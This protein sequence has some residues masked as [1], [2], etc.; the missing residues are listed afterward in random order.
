MV[1]VLADVSRGGYF[2]IAGNGI[3]RMISS[4]PT[5][6]ERRLKTIDW[7][8]QGFIACRWVR[9]KFFGG[10]LGGV[11]DGSR[12][13]RFFGSRTWGSWAF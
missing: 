2:G 13:S 12:T 9:E 1:C 7:L 3:V 4:S 11:D 5:S 8:S 6:L 10:K